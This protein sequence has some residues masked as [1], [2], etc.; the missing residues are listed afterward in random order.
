VMAAEG[1]RHSH[2][3]GVGSIVYACGAPGHMNSCG[4]SR[5]D[6]LVRAS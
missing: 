1:I 3:R 2:R 4:T 5:S 6:S